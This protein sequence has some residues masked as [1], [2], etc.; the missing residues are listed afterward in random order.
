M[1]ATNDVPDLVTPFLQEE[2]P[3]MSTIP[4]FLFPAT[5]FVLLAVEPLLPGRPQ[6]KIR[7][8]IP[9]TAFFF[10]LGAAPNIMIPAAVAQA[11]G[12][13]SLLHLAWLGTW[14]GVVVTT[15]ATTFVSY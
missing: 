8:W 2:R 9:K 3:T 14:L 13:R 1:T 6:P 12:G 11:L 5:F 4:P 7:R 10:L 15:L